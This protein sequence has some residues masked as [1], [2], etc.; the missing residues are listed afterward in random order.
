MQSLEWLI[1]H[2]WWVLF[3][4]GLFWAACAGA[5]FGWALRQIRKGPGPGSGSV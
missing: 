3:D 4:F 5:L 2:L 1:W